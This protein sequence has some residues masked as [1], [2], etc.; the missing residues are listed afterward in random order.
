MKIIAIEGLDKAGKHTATSILDDHFKKEGLNVVHM[1]C[2]NYDTPTGKLIGDWLAG[3]YKVST[4]VFELL[5]AA[6]KQQLQEVFDEHEANG[7]DIILIDRYLHSMWAYGAYDNDVEWLRKLT[8]YM[9]KPDV[10][11]YLDVEPEASM[12]RLGK[13][14][15]NDIYESDALRLR[16]TYN[17]YNR[18][19]NEEDFSKVYRVD[20][21]ETPEI[22]KG[23]ILAV[24]NSF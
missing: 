13:F 10:V 11:I 3:T 17:E 8:A 7:V 21:N 22:V 5:Q 16:S 18:I 24:I 14:G 2:P 6:D 15:E 19:L 23:N 20:A 12:S 1:T 4:K 9:R